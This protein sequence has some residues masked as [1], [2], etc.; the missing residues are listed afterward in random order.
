MYLKEII[1]CA[2]ILLASCTTP[3]PVQQLTTP[4]PQTAFEEP[5]AIEYLEMGFAQYKEKYWL[6]AIKSFE[7]AIYTEELNEAGLLVAYWTIASC[8]MQIGNTDKAASILYDFV[9]VAQD[10]LESKQQYSAPDGSDF[11]E[12]FELEDKLDYAVHYINIVWELNKAL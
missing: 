10:V 2:G 6:R 9:L 4:T 1:I 5:V 8:Y 3:I 11:S 7:N 12:Y